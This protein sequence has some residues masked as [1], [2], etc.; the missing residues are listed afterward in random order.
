MKRH[1]FIAEGWTGSRTRWRFIYLSMFP[2]KL[3]VV[4]LRSGEIILSLLELGFPH[5]DLLVLS[6][7]LQQG[8]H[9]VDTEQKDTSR[10]LI[11]C[12]RLILLIFP[13]SRIESHCIDIQTYC[14]CCQVIIQLPLLWV[15]LWH[16][17]LPPSLFLIFTMTTFCFTSPTRRTKKS[18]Q[19]KVNW[20]RAMKV[21][22]CRWDY[23]YITC[24]CC[25]VIVCTVPW[26]TAATTASSWVWGMQHSSSGSLSWLSAA[27]VS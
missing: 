21:I 11:S 17:F 26:W 19:K 20:N 6:G 9:L 8:L 14:F 1:W 12:I 22:T 25:N 24:L 3:S 27:A 18:K 23:L 5:L 15:L 13:L 10:E 16:V 4:L 2:F 7:H